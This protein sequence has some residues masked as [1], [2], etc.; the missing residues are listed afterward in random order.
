MFY[1]V[2]TRDNLLYKLKLKLLITLTTEKPFMA[3]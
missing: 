2:L 1:V 3:Q